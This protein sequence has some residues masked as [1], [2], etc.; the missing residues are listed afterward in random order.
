MELT[1][2]EYN[3]ADLEE[4]LALFYDTV[5]NVCSKDYTPGQLDAWA[6]V[7]TDKKRWDDTLL[8]TYAVVAVRDDSIA[9]FA[10]I[11]RTGH[12]D[13]LYVHSSCQGNGVGGALLREMEAFAARE[14]R[15]VISVEASLTARDFFL[16]H[17]YRIVKEQMVWRNGEYITNYVMNKQTVTGASKL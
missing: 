1:L 8:R 4:I 2:R 14:E 6:P 17:G 13:R 3:S 7:L 15:P 5:H 11:D 9:G 12:L 10:N 16:R